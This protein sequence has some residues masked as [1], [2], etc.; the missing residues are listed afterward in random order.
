MKFILQI[1]QK[2]LI[3]VVK[4]LLSIRNVSTL[5]KIESITTIYISMN[6]FSLQPGGFK[7]IIQSYKL[8]QTFF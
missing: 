3:P 1:L 7:Y 8:K 6:S 5:E 4:R 2:W